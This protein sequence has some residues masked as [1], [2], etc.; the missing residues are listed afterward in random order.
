MVVAAVAAPAWAV[1]PGDTLSVS[2]L[3]MAGPNGAWTNVVVRVTN[4]STK[5]HVANNVAVTL[6]DGTDITLTVAT[7]PTGSSSINAGGYADYT[8]TGN[9]TGGVAVKRDTTKTTVGELH[10]TASASYFDPGS[11]TYTL[12]TAAPTV[13]L[14]ANNTS[15]QFTV[16]V[17]NPAGNPHTTVRIPLTYTLTQSGNQYPVA[18]WANPPQPTGASWNSPFNSGSA[19]NDLL[20]SLDGGTTGSNLFTTQAILTGSS[21]HNSQAKIGLAASGCTS[22]NLTN[23]IANPSSVQITG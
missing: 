2:V 10:A 23:S 8:F 9:G 17:T 5:G 1:S 18:T 13:T 3:S 11:T 19:S 4:N 16:Q 20:I 21:F 22:S 12:P 7:P 15:K 14:V 6:A